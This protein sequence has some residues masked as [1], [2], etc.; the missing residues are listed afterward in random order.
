MPATMSVVTVDV[1]FVRGGCLATEPGKGRR[2]IAR[3]A[4]RLHASRIDKL[5]ATCLGRITKV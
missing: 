3:R 5:T 4:L 2:F 1:I